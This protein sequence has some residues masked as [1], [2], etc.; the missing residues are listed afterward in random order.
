MPF[1]IEENNFFSS[2]LL[3]ASNEIVICPLYKQCFVDISHQ[4]AIFSKIKFHSKTFQMPRIEPGD[5]ECEAPML[6]QCHVRPP[7]NSEKYFSVKFGAD[8]ILSKHSFLSDRL[9]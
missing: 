9:Q 6:P 4:N 7:H 3:L 1:Q 2:A 5:A 8:F